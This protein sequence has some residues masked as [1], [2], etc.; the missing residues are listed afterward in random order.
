MHLDFDLLSGLGASE[1]H[2]A[3]SSKLLPDCPILAPWASLCSWA[4]VARWRTARC[5][6]CRARGC[7]HRVRAAAVGKPHQI[8]LQAAGVTC[9]LSVGLP[10]MLS[11]FNGSQMLLHG[12]SPAV[13][14]VLCRC[15]EV[16]KTRVKRQN[17]EQPDDPEIEARTSQ[18]TN[19]WWWVL[20]SWAAFGEPGCASVAHAHVL[21]SSRLCSTLMAAPPTQPNPT[22][23]CPQVCLL[24]SP[25]GQ[26]APAPAS[27]ARRAAPP[28]GPGRGCGG[29]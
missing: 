18:L 27:H 22:P 10:W 24:P 1:A 13:P 12:L 16:T 6:T 29:E 21:H 3:G 9:G 8:A 20:N 14:A 19:T 25:H 17:V 15:A 5:A 4:S 23:P 11:P 26:P 2:I 7:W 28:H